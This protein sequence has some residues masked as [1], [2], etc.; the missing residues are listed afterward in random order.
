MGGDDRY[1]TAHHESGHATAVLLCRD[2]ELS[3]VAIDCSDPCTSPGHPTV[4]HY[5]YTGT[6][7]KP[8]DEQF[9]VYAGPWAEARCQWTGDS[10]DGEDDDGQLFA[11]YVAAAF[12]RNRD[13]DR[14]KYERLEDGWIGPDG[15]LCESL[16]AR[17]A[18]L[19]RRD[20]YELIAEREQQWSRDLERYWPVI[21]MVARTLL[22]G[23]TDVTA[24][25]G[26]V[27]KALAD[28]ND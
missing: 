26:V 10:L 25:T 20:R 5:G 19:V 14:E 7:E 24:I 17:T 4:K 3:S 11:D 1:P 9:V 6:R 23:C 28:G 2:G 12:L 22:D 18:R 16:T 21:C 8:W 15:K 13:D 27:R